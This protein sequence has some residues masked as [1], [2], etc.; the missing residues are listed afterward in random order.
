LLWFY[1]NFYVSPKLML[2]PLLRKGRHF[3]LGRADQE[4]E[5]RWPSGEVAPL[6]G[7]FRR[8]FESIV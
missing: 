3:E 7:D 2:M 8:P 4:D 1:V 5:L 6:T